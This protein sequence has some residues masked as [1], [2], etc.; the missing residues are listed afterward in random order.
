MLFETLDKT[1][2]V[3]TKQRVKERRKEEKENGGKKGKQYARLDD[4]GRSE[5]VRKRKK[6]RES[7][8]RGKERGREAK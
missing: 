8:I 2:A 4:K 3:S 1:T 7:V 5:R 6:E